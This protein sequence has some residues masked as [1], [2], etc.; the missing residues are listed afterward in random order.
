M[1]IID[2]KVKKIYENNNYWN[3]NLIIILL[4][5]I[6]ITSFPEFVPSP[7]KR[8]LS[9]VKSVT[10]SFPQSLTRNYPSPSM[11]TI[12]LAFGLKFSAILE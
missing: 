3:D 12:V 9:L 5:L 8:L 4:L 10:H 7:L 2:L 6:I 11:H 1:Y